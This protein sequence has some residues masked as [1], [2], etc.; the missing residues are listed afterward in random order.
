MNKRRYHH[1]GLVATEPMEGE[2]Y[3]ENWKLSLTPYDKS[4]FHLQWC[5]Y[6]EGCPLPELIKTVP[7][8]AFIVDDLEKAMEG[9]KVIYGPFS[10]M[11]N[12]RVAFIEECGAPVEL[13]ETTLTEEE[14]KNA[15]QIAFETQSLLKDETRS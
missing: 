4:E 15:E 5:R 11:K 12:W 3:I 9:K 10:S 1:L 6:H 13:I 7:H 14:V 8:V 2:H